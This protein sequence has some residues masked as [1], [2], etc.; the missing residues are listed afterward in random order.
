[1]GAE[2]NNHDES[3]F[4][5]SLNEHLFHL[6]HASWDYPY[7]MRFLVRALNRRDS[8]KSELLGF[9]TRELCSDSSTRHWGRKPEAGE[10]PWKM[11]R[12][13]E[14]L[15]PWGWKDPRNS[16][17]LPI[18][19]EIFPSARV[20]HIYRNGVDVSASLFRREANRG[21]KLRNPL[22]SCRC[23]DM[24]E[25]FALWA[26]YVRMCLT[27]TDALGDRAHTIRYESLLTDPARCIGDLCRFLS[28]PVTRES[29]STL[30]H[31]IRGDRA[32]AF[33]RDPELRSIYEACR[34][35]PLMKRLGYSHR[36]VQ[37]PQ[38]RMREGSFPQE[39]SLAL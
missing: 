30:V 2:L 39:S 5:L 27:F 7:P 25:A 6:A 24:E 18:W 22:F 16:L 31:E 28:I 21:D 38:E 15:G 23:L 35:D 1:M 10:G 14:G 37:G 8:F 9:L 36:P 33:L 17:T 11:E 3:L 32:F 20:V 13:C 4:F 34:N 19:A 26:E 12:I 29:L